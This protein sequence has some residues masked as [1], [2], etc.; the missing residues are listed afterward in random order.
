MSNVRTKPHSRF[1]VNRSGTL[2]PAEI[3]DAKEIVALELQ[4]EAADTQQKMGWVSL[5]SIIGFTGLLFSPIVSIERVTALSGAIDMFYISLAGV[6]GAVVGVK[7]WISNSRVQAY[8]SYSYEEE[9]E[10][11]TGPTRPSFG[12]YGNTY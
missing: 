12:R 6:V 1:D 5:A 10:E 7:A 9:R 8:S 3:R 4:E 11:S 2:S